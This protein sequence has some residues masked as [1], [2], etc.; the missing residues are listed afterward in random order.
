MAKLG[1]AVRD[2]GVKDGDVVVPTP[3]PDRGDFPCDKVGLAASGP[4]EEDQKQRA[5][6]A[7]LRFLLLGWH[8]DSRVV[9]RKGVHLDR[10]I[11]DGYRVAFFDGRPLDGLVVEFGSVATSEV[12]EDERAI[13]LALDAAMVARGALV[14]DSH[15]VLCPAP[16]A[17]RWL[18]T[19]DH[20]ALVALGDNQ[21]DHA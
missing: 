10:G 18:A 16:D 11:P 2:A 14:G 3:P 5:L 20:A 17:Y 12:V 9:W 15:G 19:L 8:T 21:P 1:V 13:G 7:G 6:A 4:R